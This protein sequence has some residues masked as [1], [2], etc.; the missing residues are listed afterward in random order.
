MP[1]CFTRSI[2]LDNWAGPP[3]KY[4][5]C[6]GCINPGHQVTVA[7]KLW[8]MAPDVCGLWVWNLLNSTPLVPA[9]LRPHFSFWKI[10][11]RLRK[12]S[13]QSHNRDCEYSFLSEERNSVWM[14]PKQISVFI[15]FV[16]P[17]NLLD[18]LHCGFYKGLPYAT[19]KE[20]HRRLHYRV[21]S[22]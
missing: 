22:P 4:L 6:R 12:V 11:A 15:V 20:V 8:T 10:C 19:G 17:A 21:W 5:Q 16:N 3:S 7:T 13:S 14:Y 2:G 9:I 1:G 18:L